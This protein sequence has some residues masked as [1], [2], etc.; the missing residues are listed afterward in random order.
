[1]RVA[2]LSR[3]GVS[4]SNDDSYSLWGGQKYHIDLPETAYSINQT[5]KKGDTQWLN[6]ASS[7][8]NPKN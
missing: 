7:R 1:M 2:D 5:T 8:P 3:R 6:N 4:K